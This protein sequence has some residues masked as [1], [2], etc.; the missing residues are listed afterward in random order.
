MAVF[1]GPAVLKEVGFGR[2]ETGAMLC[3]GGGAGL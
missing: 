1:S 2:S 3:V